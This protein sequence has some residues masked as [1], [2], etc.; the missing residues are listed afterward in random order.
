[1]SRKPLEE[2]TFFVSQL[3]N[4]DGGGAWKCGGSSWTLFEPAMLIWKQSHVHN[5]FEKIPEGHLDGKHYFGV[6]EIQAVAEGKFGE[7]T[8][9]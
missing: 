5:I 3:L 9:F 7:L 6:E 1:M 2:F 4:T 8:F